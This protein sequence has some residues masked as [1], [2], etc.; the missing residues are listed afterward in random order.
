MSAKFSYVNF[1]G[2]KFVHLAGLIASLRGMV[3]QAGGDPETTKI[4]L[5]KLADW[6]E[7][8]EFPEEGIYS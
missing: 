8:F 4:D 2:K 5:E 1:H 6:L 7:K 3:E